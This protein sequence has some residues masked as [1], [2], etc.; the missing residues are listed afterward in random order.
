MRVIPFLAATMLFALTLFGPAATN[1]PAAVDSDDDA[2]AM[3]LEPLDSES[4]YSAQASAE[5]KLLAATGHE[6]LTTRDIN[7]RLREIDLELDPNRQ[8]L[9]PGGNFHDVP[10]YDYVITLTTDV[11]Q[12]EDR[13][14][15]ALADFLRGNDKQM[16]WLQFEAQPFGDLLEYLTA[17]AKINHLQEPDSAGKAV[18]SD[19][20]ERIDRVRDNRASLAILKESTGGP[21][22]PIDELRAIAG[23][24]PGGGIVSKLKSYLKKVINEDFLREILEE[25]DE[26]VGLASWY[27]SRDEILVLQ[28][29]R[30][31]LLQIITEQA[32]AERNFRAGDDLDQPPFA[33]FPGECVKDASFTFL[34]DLSCRC[35]DGAEWRSE[36]FAITPLAG[37]AGDTWQDGK[38]KFTFGPIMPASACRPCASTLYYQVNDACDP[39]ATASGNF[40]WGAIQ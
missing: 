28:E 12:V 35:E 6:R 36:R 27:R 4:D 13:A 34:V 22:N 15:Q 20:Q 5:E 18:W 33:E 16:E 30:G 19:F 17:L 32:I 29:E 1:A 11:D 31:E 3:G 8:L 23:E 2:Q 38:R 40:F 9:G 10:F 7:R 21:F 25:P 14:W 37:N 26:G 24:R 39:A